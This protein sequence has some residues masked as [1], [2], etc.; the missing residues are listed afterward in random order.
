MALSDSQLQE[1]LNLRK[2]SEGDRKILI[3]EWNEKR[4]D[5]KPIGR[6]SVRTPCRLKQI[7]GSFQRWLDQKKDVS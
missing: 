2:W 4:L 6:N 7:V 3:E 5:V 1:L